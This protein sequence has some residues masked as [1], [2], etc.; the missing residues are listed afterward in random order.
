M[1]HLATHTNDV[2]VFSSPAF[3]THANLVLR[4]PVLRFPPAFWSRAFQSYLFRPCHLVPCFP[5]LLFPTPYFSWSRVFRSRV[6]SRPLITSYWQTIPCRLHKQV[7]SRSKPLT[8]CHVLVYAASSTFYMV[9]E[10]TKHYCNKQY[11]ISPTNNKNIEL[12]TTF[13]VRRWW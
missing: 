3:S 10:N 13:V 7:H 8:M 6:F 1:L 11:Y 4:F 9:W 12:F 2:P 5:V